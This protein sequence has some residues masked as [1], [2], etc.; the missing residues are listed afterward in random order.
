[1]DTTQRI[2]PSTASAPRD[3]YPAVTIHAGDRVYTVDQ[4]Q[5]PIVIGR[6]VAAHVRIDDEHVSATHLRLEHTPAGWVAVDQSR[7]GSFLH[8]TRRP[9]IPITGATTINLGHARGVAVTVTEDSTP[10]PP[11]DID[12]RDDDADVTMETGATDPGVARAGAAVAARRKELDLPQRYLAANGI[13]SAGS[14]IDF[15]KG[16][17]WPRRATRARLEEALGWPPG[18]IAL[19]R[20]QPV[21]PDDEQTIALT[22]SAGMPMMAEV[23]ELALNNIS[24]TIESL[25]AIADPDFTVRANRTLA[26]LRKLESSAAR[27]ARA[28]TG[29]SALAKLLGRIRKAYKN[30]MLRA[31]RAPAATLGQQLFAARHRAELSIDEFANAAGVPAETVM[32][33]E[34][35]AALDDDTVAALASALTFLTGR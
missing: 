6:D 23:L 31:A 14:L 2:T 11:P 4:S 16:R 12:T 22:N 21:N 5:A 33:A 8:G 19:I 24:T 3:R 25:P 26:D 7:N 32:A 15:E 20:N 13:M 17:R 9:R 29:D 10:P 30:L 27:A 1:V 35:G 28:A 34:D 18:R